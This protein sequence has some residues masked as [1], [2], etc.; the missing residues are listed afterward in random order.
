VIEEEK[1]GV[2]WK[3][4]KECWQWRWRWVEKSDDNDKRKETVGNDEERK[5]VISMKRKENE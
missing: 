5:R 2:N 4:K 1:E 3:E